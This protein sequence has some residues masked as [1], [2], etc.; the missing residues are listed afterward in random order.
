MPV[1]SIKNKEINMSS[2]LVLCREDIIQDIPFSHSYLLSWESNLNLSSRCLD[3]RI[4][5]VDVWKHSACT[6]RGLMSLCICRYT[7]MFLKSRLQNW[8]KIQANDISY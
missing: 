3:G 7:V 5:V 1:S 2:Q 4:S 8:Y 6:E